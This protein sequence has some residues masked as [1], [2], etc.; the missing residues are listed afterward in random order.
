MKY[1]TN[2]LDFQSD[3]RSVI[4]LGKFDGLHRGH[5]KLI[6][7]ILELGMQGYET[8]VFTFDVS[9][10]VKLGT[11]I[12][13]TLL[14]NDERRCLLEKMNV[15]CLIECP[16][17]PELIQM[18]PEDFIKKILVDQLQ[19][20]YIV[21]GPDF[22]FGHDRKGNTAFLQELSGKYGY[23]LIIL[24]KE[25]EEDRAISSTW[26]RELLREGRMENVNHLLGYPYFVIESVVH[27]R[28]LG[29][30]W[31]LPTI[32]QIPADGKLLPP[33]GVYATRTTINGKVYFG[34]SNVGVKPTV[35]E[36]FAGVETYLFDCNE[37]L[38]EKEAWVE[39][40]HFVRP[41]CKFDS[42]EELK[43]QIQRDAQA[44]QKYFE[45]W[46]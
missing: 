10:L 23:E 12:K 41:E 42:V 43:E 37:N 38:Y 2:T 8:V 16:F 3:K 32:N 34:I 39:F 36:T 1:I 21:V 15:D 44:G 28:Q 4:T 7:K 35:K 14:N 24:E 22:R 33:F 45:N 11:R 26:V 31:G 9:P 17:V 29:R 27:G 46:K 19:A 25:M 40:F 20:A 30:T 13:R 18:E 5:Q 6:N